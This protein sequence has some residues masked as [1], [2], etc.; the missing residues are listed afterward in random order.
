MVNRAGVRLREWLE[1]ERRSQMWLSEQ[2]G[3]HQTNVS[4]WIRGRPI[5]LAAAIAIEKIAG[6]PVGDWVAE[7]DET[8]PRLPETGT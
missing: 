1:A 2:I 4:A 5:P 3:T 7:A 6:I 8:G